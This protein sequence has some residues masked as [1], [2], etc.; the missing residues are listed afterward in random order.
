MSLPNFAYYSHHKCATG[1]TTSILMEF[2]F[3]LGRRFRIAH[4]PV[5]Y[6]ADGGLRAWVARHDVEFL[7]YTNAEMYEVQSLP[8][9]QGVHV[10]RDP[11]DVLV[12]AYFSHKNSHPTENWPELET[13]REA[14]RSLSKEEGLLKEIE[15]SRPFLEAMQTWDYDQEHI[16]EM[17]MENLTANP[18]TRFRR[19]L[20]HLGLFEEDPDEGL[21]HRGRHYGNRLLYK[22]YHELPLSPPR[23]LTVEPTLHPSVL[24][25]IL[26]AHRFERMTDGRSKGE[27]DPE[28]HYRKGEPGDW[29]NHFTD[30]VRQAFE[31]AYGDIVETLG[32]DG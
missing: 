15:F 22:A 14:L 28:S 10:V 19:M 13:H 4:G 7:A 30:R 29:K 25:E 24:D 32:Y 20:R 9:H 21:L 18:D 11:R 16:L 5:Q 8:S 31:D 3:H 12:S 2:C 23:R 26:E 6:G 1:W 27:A 17:K